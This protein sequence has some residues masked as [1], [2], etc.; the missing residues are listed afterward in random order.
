MRRIQ[1]FVDVRARGTISTNAPNPS[2]MNGR[3][4]TS[5][6]IADNAKFRSNDQYD[7]K[8]QNA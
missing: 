3:L 7:M 4:S 5:A 8:W 6:N 2:A 1:P